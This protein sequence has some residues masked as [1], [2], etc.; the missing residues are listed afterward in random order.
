MT[1][2]ILAYVVLGFVAAVVVLYVLVLCWR[3]ATKA[4]NEEWQRTA[5]LEQMKKHFV[6][7][8]ESLAAR[9]HRDN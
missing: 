3:A 4:D 1:R 9:K 8:R 2:L 7:T 5:E 6:N